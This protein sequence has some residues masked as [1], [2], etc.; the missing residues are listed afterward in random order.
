MAMQLAWYR[1]RGEFT[2]TYETALTRLFDRGRTET[3]RT[4][5]ADSRAWVLGMCD[6]HCDVR[7]AIPS[8][9]PYLPFLVE[10]DPVGSTQAC[11]TDPYWFD[12]SSRNWPWI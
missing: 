7:S 4:L 8:L 6:P 1:T 2:A 9:H 10:P 3:I 11:H 5:S 12:T